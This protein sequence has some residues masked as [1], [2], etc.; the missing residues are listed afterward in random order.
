MSHKN[1][2]SE[3]WNRRYRNANDGQDWKPSDGEFDA[4]IPLTILGCIIGIPILL[5]IIDT[6]A[7]ALGEPSMFQGR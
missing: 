3:D 1:N 5:V 2:M 4:V 6:I 7:I